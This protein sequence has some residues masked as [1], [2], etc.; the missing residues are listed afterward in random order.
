MTA[1]KQHFEG[2]LSRPTRSYIL[3]VRSL[4]DCAVDLVWGCGSKQEKKRP[5]GH[6]GGSGIRDRPTDPAPAGRIS[7]DGTT[8][9]TSSALSTVA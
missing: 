2:S 1:A 9:T 4:V 8:S 3:P 6:A 5:H 7:S